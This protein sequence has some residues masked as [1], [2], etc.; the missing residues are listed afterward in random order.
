[1]FQK[2]YWKL[3][4]RRGGDRSVLERNCICWKKL[5]SKRTGANELK[6]IA[7]IIIFPSE[8]RPLVNG[9]KS[10]I[11][12]KTRLFLCC[13][14]SA[15]LCSYRRCLFILKQFL[16]R[17]NSKNSSH[18]PYF[19]VGWVGE[20][21]EE[22]KQN[23]SNAHRGLIRCNSRRQRFPCGVTWRSKVSITI[24]IIR[25]ISATWERK[26]WK[27]SQKNKKSLKNYYLI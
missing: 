4:A 5:R 1:M 23:Y 26:L 11:S 6:S 13:I 15:C 25:W 9:L 20:G 16:S 14:L 3:K 2:Q 10:K 24:V 21:G 7:L 27:W 18:L 22:F 19:F 12:S 17:S 8:N